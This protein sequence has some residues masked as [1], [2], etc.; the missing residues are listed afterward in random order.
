M[1]PST[2]WVGESPHLLYHYF[3]LFWNNIIHQIT[4]T[5]EHPSIMIWEALC[6]LCDFGH[7]VL[8]GWQVEATEQEQP[9]LKTSRGGAVSLVQEIWDVLLNAGIFV[10]F[11]LGRVGAHVHSSLVRIGTLCIHCYPPSCAGNCS[12]LVLCRLMDLLDVDGSATISY[13]EF[14]AA[15]TVH[16]LA[17]PA[18]ASITTEIVLQK[19]SWCAA[20]ILLSSVRGLRR[21]DMGEPPVPRKDRKH[22]TTDSTCLVPRKNCRWSF[23][24]SFANNVHDM[25]HD[26]KVVFFAVWKRVYFSFL[27]CM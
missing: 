6:Q 19:F 17:Q 21:T 4:S 8:Q 18:S 15:M 20:A 25:K 13:P 27:L 11:L 9:F 26:H 5:F 7:A 23:H 3:G 16:P 22:Y 1:S 2:V 12:L 10:S 14:I 24:G